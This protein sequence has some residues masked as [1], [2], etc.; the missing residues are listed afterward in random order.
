MM[1]LLLKVGASEQLGRNRRLVA[2]LVG[3]F[4]SYASNGIIFHGASP[5]R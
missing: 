4:L 5:F 1:G 2:E 3:V